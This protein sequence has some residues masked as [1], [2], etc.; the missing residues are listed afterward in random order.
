LS[1]HP[2]AIDRSRW[3]TYGNLGEQRRNLWPDLPVGAPQT[4]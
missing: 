2:A 4:D 3:L 1:I